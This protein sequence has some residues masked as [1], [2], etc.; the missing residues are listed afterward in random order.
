M[1]RLSTGFLA[2]GATDMDWL[3]VEKGVCEA[4]GTPHSFSSFS[5]SFE[6]HRPY[7]IGQR[8]PLRYLI[9]WE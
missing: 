5:K 6:A 2:S 4:K 3:T 9:S 7:L 8:G 1:R